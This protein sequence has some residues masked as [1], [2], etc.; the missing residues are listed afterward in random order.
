M[1]CTWQ[2]QRNHPSHL[3]IIDVA[4]DSRQE[5]WEHAAAFQFDAAAVYSHIHHLFDGH[6][7]TKECLED[8]LGRLGRQATASNKNPWSSMA[9]EKFLF[10]NSRFLRWDP[11]EYPHMKLLDGDVMNKQFAKESSRQQLFVGSNAR[12]LG[13]ELLESVRQHHYH[14]VPGRVPVD[15]FLRCCL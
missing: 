6:V 15:L 10:Y 3:P 8:V 2:L 11:Q 12:R 4:P 14:A 9:P 1:F 7:S 5:T 13:C